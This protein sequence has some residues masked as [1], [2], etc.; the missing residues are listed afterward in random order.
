MNK[1]LENKEIEVLVEN[2]TDKSSMYFGRS[3]YMTPVIFDA[4]DDDVGN[5]IKVKINRSNRNTL[6]GNNL[7]KSEKKVA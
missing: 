2:K 5:L 6:F 3:E 1:S 7:N 4:N